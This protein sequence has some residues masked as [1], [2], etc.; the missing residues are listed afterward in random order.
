MYKSWL[1]RVVEAVPPF[2]I[3]VGLSAGIFTLFGTASELAYQEE[4]EALEKQQSH[5]RQ[6][7]QDSHKYY[8]LRLEQ[9]EIADVA[10]VN[11]ESMTAQEFLWHLED[12]FDDNDMVEV[13]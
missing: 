12:V 10:C 4:L 6:M 13:Y 2:L 7:L 5:Y 9:Q 11:V 1:D 3:G 8:N